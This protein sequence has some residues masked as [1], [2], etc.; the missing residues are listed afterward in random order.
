MVATMVIIAGCVAA[1]AGLIAGFL[2]FANDDAY[3][4]TL[5]FEQ[6]FTDLALGLGLGAI[7]VAAGF[8]LRISARRQA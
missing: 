4:T 1:A 7:A 3:N 5:K 6:F 8:F 2:A